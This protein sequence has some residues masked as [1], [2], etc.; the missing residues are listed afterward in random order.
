MKTYQL[1]FSF[2]HTPP[3]LLRGRHALILLENEEGKFVLGAKHIYPTGIFRLVGGGIEEGEDPH[4]AAARE[5]QEEFGVPYQQEQLRPLA[6]ITAH[7][8]ETS[9]GRQLLF[10]TYLYHAKCQ[11]QMLQPSDDLDGMVAYSREEI[12][13]LVDRYYDLS[14]ALITVSGSDPDPKK[15]LPFSWSDYGKFYGR[16]HEIAMEVL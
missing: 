3:V 15:D 5:L 8:Q 9:T 12:N 1:F 6:E 7:I 16:V 11:M 10:V 4:A 14:D 13:A 2:A